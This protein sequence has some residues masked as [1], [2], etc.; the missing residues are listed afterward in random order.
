MRRVI[1][2]MKSLGEENRFR[3]V[4]MLSQRP[5]CVC[6]LASVL[7]IAL[8]TLSSHLKQLS[9]AGILIGEKDGRWI[10]YRISDDPLIRRL[11]DLLRGELLEDPTLRSD[12]ELAAAEDRDSCAIALREQ[13]TGRR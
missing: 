2:I 3:I 11:V 8:S 7:D 10:S 12:L 6:E 13:K 1:Q 9:Y 4:M 5:M